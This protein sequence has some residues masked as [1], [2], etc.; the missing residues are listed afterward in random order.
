VNLTRRFDHALSFALHLHRDQKL[1]GTDAPYSAHLLSVA[2]LVLRFGGSEDQAIAA[3]LHDA[4][5]DAGGRPTLEFIRAQ[6]GDA[7]A[8]IVEDSTDTMK[9]PK[10]EWRQ[11]KER[12]VASIPAKAAASLLVIACDKL[13]N[14]RA[15]VADLRS[16]GPG[17]LRRFAGG[18]RTLWY[19]E[20]LAAA[21]LRSA[22]PGTRAAAVARELEIVVREMRELATPP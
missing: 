13:D 1:K 16:E 15:I 3:L 2:G 10:P 4:A 6:F 22:S 9:S 18:R 7:V 14:G 12:Y 19:Y 11:R 17:T 5:E 21:L 20:A 8:R